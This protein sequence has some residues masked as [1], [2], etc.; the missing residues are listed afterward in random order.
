[1]DVND[2]VSSGLQLFGIAK[3]AFVCVIIIWLP[4]LAGLPLRDFFLL[5]T[6]KPNM[7]AK[8]TQHPDE[9]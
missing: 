1:M 9:M 5:D 7:V 6:I 3:A 8:G 2:P 4:V